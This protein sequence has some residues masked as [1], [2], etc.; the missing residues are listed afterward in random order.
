MQKTF[1]FAALTAFVLSLSGASAYA[2]K[3]C[4]DEHGRFM[5]CAPVQHHYMFD[6]HHKCRDEHGRFA[7]MSM[8]H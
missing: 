2:A 4:R 6:K 7:K 3:P 5:K 1:A 8:C